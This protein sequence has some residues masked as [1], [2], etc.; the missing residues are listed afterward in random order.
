M[1]FLSTIIKVRELKVKLQTV[2]HNKSNYS[3]LMNFRLDFL[4]F[5]SN[6]SDYAFL[7]KCL[8]AYYIF[9]LI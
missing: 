1:R 8:K 5:E 3:D 6:F 2:E 7:F 4:L 9:T